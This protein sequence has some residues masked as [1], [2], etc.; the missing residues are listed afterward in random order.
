M[1]TIKQKVAA[2][3]MQVGRVI[4]S[5]LFAA[6]A[7]CMA[8]VVLA[9][10]ISVNSHA[11][12]ITDG[13]TS[14]VVLTMHNDP[15]KVLASAG[16]ALEQHDAVEV[17]AET[18]HIEVQRAME[19]QV[20][21]DGVTTMLYMTS[22]TV[23][24]A[25]QRAEVTVG[26]QDTINIKQDAP[27]SEGLCVTVDRVAY[28]EYT[29]TETIDYDV[30]TRYTFVLRPGQTTVLSAGQEGERT[31]TYRQTI[32]NGK[33]TETE[34]VSEKV[35]KKAVTK[36]VLK[37]SNYGAVYSKAP[38]HVELDSKNQPV[39]YKKKFSG[40]CTAYATGSRGAS[41]M[42][43]GV[44]TVAVNPKQ[45]PYG[46]KLWVTSADG[47]YVYGYAVAADTGGFATR[48]SALIDVYMGSYTE[49]CN[50]GARHMNVY[51][52]E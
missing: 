5:R 8:A 6:A 34:T 35:T 38:F 47:K 43:L 22:G 49:A 31:I 1:E 45:I 21:A 32:V 9:V 39:N 42:R 15:Y 46:T 36:Q 7:M 50:F 14:R 29:A 17:N 18:E 3:L 19:V 28:R 20:Q 40:R 52:L 33:V 25:L 2:L 11:V 30:N 48:G 23:A 44:G 41:G 26:P 37:G 51:V 24:D 13:D 16:V 27:V 10:G 4:R 12:T